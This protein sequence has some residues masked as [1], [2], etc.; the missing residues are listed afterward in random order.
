MISLL[1][2]DDPDKIFINKDKIVSIE[3]YL[4]GTSEVLVIACLLNNVTSA[5]YRLF[6]LFLGLNNL[7][8]LLASNLLIINPILLYS[9]KYC[10]LFSNSD[11]PLKPLSFKSAIKAGLK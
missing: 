2:K 6:I 1:K 7:K 4:R 11:I 8:K 9:I 10:V 3:E 5:F